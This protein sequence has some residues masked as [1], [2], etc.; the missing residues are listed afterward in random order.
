MEE[1]P[2]VGAMGAQPLSDIIGM[3]DPSERRM[4]EI[5]CLACGR[6]WSDADAFWAEADPSK[7]ESGPSEPGQS[8]S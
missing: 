4:P 3:G 2:N 8:G 6:R 1:L 5:V 7:G